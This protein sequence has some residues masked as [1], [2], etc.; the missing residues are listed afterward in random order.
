MNEESA[1]IQEIYTHMG[2]YKVNRLM[3]GIKT[4]PNFWQNTMD[5]ILTIDRSY[6]GG[7]FL[8]QYC[9]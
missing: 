1:R 5:R 6:R 7:M 9:D 8:R 3:F 4:A 2:T